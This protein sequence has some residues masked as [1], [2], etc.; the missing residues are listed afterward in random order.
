VRFLT[1]DDPRV[2]LV[3]LTSPG[4]GVLMA[5]LQSLAE[6][7]ITCRLATPF[8]VTQASGTNYLGLAGHELALEPGGVVPVEVPALGI[9]AVTLRLRSAA[10]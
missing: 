5:R 2:R 1:V 9:A 8:P 10:E 6:V 4:E 7:P 3:G